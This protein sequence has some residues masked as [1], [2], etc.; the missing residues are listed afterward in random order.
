MALMYSPFSSKLPEDRLRYDLYWC[1]I[2]AAPEKLAGSQAGRLRGRKEGGI[3]PI[4]KQWPK[5]SS[6]VQK[7]SADT[8]LDIT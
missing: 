7:K 4:K 2:Q 5:L 1:N 8:D 3:H 6:V